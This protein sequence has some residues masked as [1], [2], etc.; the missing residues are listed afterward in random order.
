MIKISCIFFSIKIEK[1]D[2][3]LL[4][5]SFSRIIGLGFSPKTIGLSIDRALLSLTMCHCNS[6]LVNVI[7]L[8]Q[9]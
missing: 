9:S 5:H 4:Q 2:I 7:L 3:Y 1:E 6:C 8:G